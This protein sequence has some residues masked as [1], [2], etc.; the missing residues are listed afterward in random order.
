MSTISRRDL[1][2]AA[3]FIMVSPA[4]PSFA[5]AAQAKSS[6]PVTYEARAKTWEE[7]AKELSQ[8]LGE[9]LTVSPLLAKERAL[10]RVADV[11]P[12]DLKKQIAKVMYATWE[13][14]G[15]GFQLKQTTADR[16]RLEKYLQAERAEKFKICMQ[17]VS[18]SIK[19]YYAEQAERGYLPLSNP[20]GALGL[21][22]VDAMG[23]PALSNIL[24]S[25]ERV[26]FSTNP[27]GMQH[28]LSDDAIRKPLERYKDECK[29][30]QDSKQRL[31]EIVPNPENIDDIAEISLSLRLNEDC[32]LEIGTMV[33]GS[34]GVALSDVLESPPSPLEKLEP[35]DN[36]DDETDGAQK[37]KAPPKHRLT[38]PDDDPFKEF[39][40]F[41]RLED[42]NILST[43]PFKNASPT[44]RAWFQDPVSYEPL[45]AITSAIFIGM[46]RWGNLVMPLYDTIFAP[47][48]GAIGGDEFTQEDFLTGLDITPE[49]NNPQSDGNRWFALKPGIAP[50]R[51]DRKS[52]RDA[53]K[54]GAPGT[55]DI[56]AM[57]DF[58]AA[59][60]P[61]VLNYSVQNIA[62]LAGSNIK[63]F[64]AS[65]DTKGGGT[66]GTVDSFEEE[67]ML[68]FFLLG[69]P[70]QALKNI[71]KG[72]TVSGQFSECPATMQQTI[73]EWLYDCAIQYNEIIFESNTPH[74]NPD[75]TKTTPVILC[76]PTRTFPHGVPSDTRI[77]VSCKV[78]KVCE[79][80]DNEGS[81][82]YSPPEFYELEE[83]QKST[84]FRP[85]D[86]YTF[87]VDVTF[88]NGLK[89]NRDC[90]FRHHIGK[91]GPLADLPKDMRDILSKAKPRPKSIGDGGVNPPAPAP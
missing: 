17:N 39:I 89:M 72:E 53:I 56:M 25:G 18:K 51:V 20:V 11:T 48:M 52:L 70:D 19:D 76:E 85:V 31:K 91:P 7:I 9:Q 67:A 47:C 80:F 57:R 2:R 4:I 65:F 49:S 27:R 63:D 86:Y 77:A 50:A 3:S 74:N 14:A 10:I 12:E 40:D 73:T 81:S 45:E 41:C 90:H 23:A 78:T 43:P 87:K 32:N 66:G 29:L 58:L 5:P 83:V 88:S 68:R 36:M 22:I 75:Y 59:N 16:R 61:G 35:P 30:Q 55:L 54:N 64:E 79:N 71:L 69:L 13:P 1:L 44:I 62:G 26:V 34:N 6:A 24:L 33:I 21:Q 8:L 37:R 60:P 28:H 84:S 38:V 46:P 82:G 42:Q 15:K